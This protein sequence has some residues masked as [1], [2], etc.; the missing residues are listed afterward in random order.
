MMDIKI[1]GD[2]DGIQ[3]ARK[4][5]ESYGIP[6][7]FLTAYS[8]KNILEK[9]KLVQ[10]LGYILK[11]YKIDELKSVVE[12]ALYK[13][14][15]EKRVQKMNK[16]LESA[17]KEKTI[18][19]TDEIEYRKR[20]EKELQNKTNYLR[21]AN[22]ALCALLKTREAEN[23]AV[24][25]EIFF[26][27]KKCLLPY[28]ELIEEEKSKEKI[29]ELI[30]MLKKKLYETLSPSSK[31]LCAKYTNLTTQEIKI[32]ELIRNGKSTKEIAKFMNISPSS[33]ATHRN[34]I[35]KKI[36]LLNSTA[37]LHTYLKSLHSL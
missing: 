35:R 34:H 28:I 18:K 26:N 6:V 2:I 3:A 12:I 7:I 8:D 36:G 31:T 24:E 11:P 10:P 17:V 37:N 22:E 9:A 5:R 33:V 25:E 30:S 27:I 19:L 1:K 21:E 32:A 29:I 15:M 4:I 13:A 23:R 20:A 14:E 16:Q